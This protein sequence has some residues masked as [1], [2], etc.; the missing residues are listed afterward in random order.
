MDGL[1][2][3]K[4][5]YKVGNPKKNLIFGVSKAL[6]LVMFARTIA[7]HKRELRITK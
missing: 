5:D 1:A 6:N 2:K 3:G 4:E 7:V